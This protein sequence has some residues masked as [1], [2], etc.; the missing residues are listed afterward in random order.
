MTKNK[1]GRGGEGRGGFIW[2]IHPHHS[3]SLNEIQSG[4][5][6]EQN[7]EPAADTEAMKGF[8]LLI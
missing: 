7:L 4:T 1:L 6:A 5:Q 8:C 3:P 2:I